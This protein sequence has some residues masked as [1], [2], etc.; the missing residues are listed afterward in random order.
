MTPEDHGQA[1][2]SM[3]DCAAA[4]CERHC[5]DG[6]DATLA[7]ISLKGQGFVGLCQDHI[8]RSV[9]LKAEAAAVYGTEVN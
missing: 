7:R 2:S 9:V 3:R 6:G 4:G 5:R 1:Y 8:G